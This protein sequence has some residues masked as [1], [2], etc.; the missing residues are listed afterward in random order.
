M[1]IDNAIREGTQILNINNI[2]SSQLDSEILMCKVIKKS[3]KFILLNQCQEIEKKTLDLFKKLINQRASG[4]PI[5]YMLGKKDF[6]KN[7]FLINSNVLIPRPDTEILIEEALKLTKQKSKLNVLDVGVG[8]GC[9]LLSIISEKKDFRGTGI[10]K[11]R[12]CLKLSKINASKLGI[13][14]RVKFFKSDVDNFRY[15][16][17]DLI[18]S[19]PPYINKI[20]LNYLEKDIVNFEPK[21]ALNGGIDGLSEIRKVIK[22]SSE[23]IKINGKLILEIGSDQKEK[24]IRL[25]K[26]KGF[27]I[28]KFL[29]DYAG[30]DRCI[31][32]TKI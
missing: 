2:K 26:N 29:K 31:V 11:S 19:N 24:V 25:L 18:I 8:S 27:Y 13:G 5:A 6:W 17:Y 28:N 7:E 21:L 23:L 9:I 12:K 16:K 14:G 20:D 15:G 4:K 32:S 30:N 22:A 10:D 3:R 1:N